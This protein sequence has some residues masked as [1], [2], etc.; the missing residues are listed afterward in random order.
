MATVAE[1]GALM[2]RQTFAWLRY[3]RESQPVMFDGA[4]YTDGR[5]GVIGTAPPLTV[6]Q[7]VESLKRSGYEECCRMVKAG[8]VIA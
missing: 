7:A 2:L 1:G 5:G 8:E 6:G 4:T 3:L